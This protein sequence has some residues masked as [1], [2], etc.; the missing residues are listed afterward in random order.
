MNILHWLFGIGDRHLQNSLMSLECGQV[1][2]IDF[3]RSFGTG[4]TMQGVPE[5]VPFRLT[6]QFEQVMQPYGCNG[7]CSRQNADNSSRLYVHGT[8]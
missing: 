6:P 2:G 8:V 3:G 4:I 7:T 5:L 1:I